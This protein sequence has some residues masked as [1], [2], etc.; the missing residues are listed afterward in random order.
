MV[1]ARGEWFVTYLN[2]YSGVKI[3]VGAALVNFFLAWPHM[4]PCITLAPF[5]LGEHLRRVVRCILIV[6]VY[7]LNFGA[8]TSTLMFTLS[9]FLPGIMCEAL[10]WLYVLRTV[11]HFNINQGI[12]V[13]LHINDVFRCAFTVQSNH[14]EVDSS[15]GRH[16]IMKLYY[17]EHDQYEFNEGVAARLAGV[18]WP[19]EMMIFRESVFGDRL[20]NMRRGDE[21]LAWRTVEQMFP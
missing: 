20:V 1:I 8:M 13:P 5:S 17:V 15:N 9:F 12:T 21:A 7:A 19:G 18:Q 2:R 4:S 10:H 16:A 11:L 3:Y 6:V 14:W